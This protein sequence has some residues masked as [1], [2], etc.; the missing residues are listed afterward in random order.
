MAYLFDIAA[1]S[2]FPLAPHHTFGRLASG[3]DTHVDKPYISKLHAAIEWTGRGWSI[4]NMGRNGTWVNDRMLGPAES[5]ALAVDDHIYLA[6]HSDPGFRVIDLAPP[7]D[8]LWPLNTG[9]TFTPVVL[10]RYHLLPD[11]AAPELALYF[12][13]RDQQ[14]YMESVSSSEES[15]TQAIHHGSRLSFSNTE[16]QF[17]RAQIYGA[18]EARTSQALRLGDLEFVFNLSL[19]EETTRLELQHPLQTLDLGVRTHHYLLLQLARHRAEDAARGLDND[20]Q[21][22]VYTAQ[23]ATELGLDVT[24]IN[25]QIFRLRKQFADHLLDAGAQQKVLERRGGRVRFGGAKF[26]IFKG[27][28]LVSVLPNHP[29]SADQ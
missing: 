16:W 13:D 1:G 21:G 29:L 19:D 11:T 3:V 25:I 17:I 23:L 12:N 9:E 20:S 8:M 24:H 28:T 7:A 10:T 5:A 14:W 18:T 4:K 15:H 2:F 6:E 22:W 27:N 26:K